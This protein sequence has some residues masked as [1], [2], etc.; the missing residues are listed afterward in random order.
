MEG[1]RDGRTDRGT[2]RGRDN[3]QTDGQTDGPTRHTQHVK[4]IQHNDLPFLAVPRAARP[5]PKHPPCRTTYNG[6]LCP[7]LIKHVDVCVGITSVVVSF[8]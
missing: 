2:D 4:I 6:S 3:G 7:L 1:G 8:N 5:S